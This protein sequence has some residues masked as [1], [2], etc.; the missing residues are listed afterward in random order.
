MF[1]YHNVEMPK[2]CIFKISPSS[3]GLFFEKPSEWYN[4]EV[5]KTE[6]RPNTPML[7][8]TICHKAL[9]F[10]INNKTLSLE[11]I[12]ENIKDIEGIDVNYILNHYNGVVNS[13]IENYLNNNQPI[14]TEHTMSSHIKDGIY[15]A[16]TCDN[17]SINNFDS[18]KIICD[19]KVLSTKLTRI[20]QK[21]KKQLLTYA[22]LYFIST[23]EIPGYIRIIQLL[24]P[25][26]TRRNLTEV[27]TEEIT[28]VDLNSI[29]DDLTFIADTILFCINNPEAAKFIFKDKNIVWNNAIS[30]VKKDKEK[31][32]IMSILKNKK[33]SNL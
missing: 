12:Q 13:C 25:N 18:K 19:Y 3:I 29:K 1:S 16:G 21:Y 26:S 17:I 2:D 33:R 11:E 22:Y 30:N 7:F 8:G 32:T 15:V 5:E 6:I 20:N 24:K 28:S 4:R 14:L 31:Q 27:L 10:Y 9:E 23:G